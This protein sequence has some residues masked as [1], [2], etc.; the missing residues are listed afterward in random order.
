MVIWILEGF[1]YSENG[2]AVP[3]EKCA[4]FDCFKHFFGRLSFTLI[5]FAYALA[6]PFIGGSNIFA[7]EFQFVSLL[8]DTLRVLT[9]RNR[10]TLSE[11]DELFFG[12]ARLGRFAISTHSVDPNGFALS[13]KGG[14]GMKFDWFKWSLYPWPPLFAIYIWEFNMFSFLKWK[15]NRAEW[16]QQQSTYTLCT[17]QNTDPFILVGWVFSEHRKQFGKF[18]WK[19]SFKESLLIIWVCVR[20]SVFLLSHLSLLVCPCYLI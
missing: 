8:T 10:Q 13:K 5:P 12:L 1:F 7:A 18:K 17:A 9:N 16:K 3:A 4:S 15:K 14:N 2:R 6:V 19:H 11:R 20:E